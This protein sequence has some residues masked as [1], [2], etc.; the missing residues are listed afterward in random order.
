MFNKNYVLNWFKSFEEIKKFLDYIDKFHTIIKTPLKKK[1][2]LK[3]YLNNIQ[4]KIKKFNESEISSEELVAI[5]QNLKAEELEY[6]DVNNFYIW[7]I[8]EDLDVPILSWSVKPPIEKNKKHFDETR[9]SEFI[10]RI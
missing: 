4:S 6:I 7:I 1:V 8:W 2:N 5:N 3:S 9:F 10:K